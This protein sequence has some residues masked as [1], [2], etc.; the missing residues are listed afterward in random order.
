MGNSTADPLRSSVGFGGREHLLEKAIRI[1][2]GTVIIT[3]NP[4]YF[5]LQSL[6]FSTQN[7]KKSSCTLRKI[8]SNRTKASETDTRV[9]K[10]REQE[11]L[12]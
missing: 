2:M 12:T 9:R 8:S 4:S 1:L 10:N 11:V 6:H 5:N 3:V 7:S